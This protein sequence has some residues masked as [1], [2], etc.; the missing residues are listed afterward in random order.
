MQFKDKVRMYLGES[1]KVR[2]EAELTQLYK[3]T[4]KILGGISPSIV[5][6]FVTSPHS[7]DGPG[8]GLNIVT[9]KQLAK[10]MEEAIPDIKD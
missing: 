9:P 10:E 3:D 8:L 6:E 4:A 7:E 5:R 2:T 1:K